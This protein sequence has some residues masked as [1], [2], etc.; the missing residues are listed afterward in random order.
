[1]SV[2]YFFGIGVSLVS[3]PAS[4]LP[5]G[6]RAAQLRAG[7]PAR[8][9]SAALGKEPAASPDFS[10]RPGAASRWEARRLEADRRAY[11]CTA[12]VRDDVRRA[13]Q[14]DPEGR[15]QKPTGRRQIRWKRSFH[16]ARPYMRTLFALFLACG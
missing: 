11:A 1:M 4:S 6:C 5:P 2:L 13:S 7:P 14:R 12:E 15:A 10:H 16:R 9:F 8:T 3:N